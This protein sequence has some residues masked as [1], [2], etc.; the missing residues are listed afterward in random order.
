VVIKM[1]KSKKEKENELRPKRPQTKTAT[2]KS[3]HQNGE[4]GNN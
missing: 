4:H 3:I 1:N 2:T